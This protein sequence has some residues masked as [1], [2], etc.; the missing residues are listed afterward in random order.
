[1]GYLHLINT[2]TNTIDKLTLSKEEKLQF[3]LQMQAQLQQAENELEES[4]R[5]ELES[6]AEIIKAELAQ[7]DKFT[8]RA[9]PS[10]IYAGLIFIGIVHVIV[11]IIAA[12]NGAE[13]PG[14]ELPDDFW[15]AWGTVV[16]VYGAGRTVE[17]LGVANKYTQAA[18]GSGAYKSK[19][20][21]DAQG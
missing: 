12:M 2:L 21:T 14:I 18:T 10:I 11:P 1:M 15:W 6:R 5:S 19:K 16:G 9:R 8:K 13:Q 3:K 4:Y 7:G 20:L 17:K